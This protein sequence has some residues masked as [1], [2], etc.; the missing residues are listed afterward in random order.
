MLVL[1]FPVCR[2][3]GYIVTL[4]YCFLSAGHVEYS[5]DDVEMME[6]DEVVAEVSLFRNSVQ[7]TLDSNIPAPSL[8][9]SPSP[10]FSQDL[11]MTSRS[12][13]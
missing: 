11:Q 1:L 12:G 6:I 7:P 2:F 3:R 13:L 8:C 4:F 10:P 9:T 5:D